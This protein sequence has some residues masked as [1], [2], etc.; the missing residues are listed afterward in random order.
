LLLY[1]RDQQ[2][3]QPTE[4]RDTVT[5]KKLIDSIQTIIKNGQ[6]FDSVCAKL[7]EDPGSKDKGGVYDNVPSGQWCRRSMILFLE[8]HPEQRAL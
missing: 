6:N 5:A 2:T 8:I 1:K 7:S 3:G 4:V